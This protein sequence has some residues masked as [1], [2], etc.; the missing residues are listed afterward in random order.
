MANTKM[1]KVQGFAQVLA[2]VNGEIEEVSEDAI[3]I[4]ENEIARL[5]KTAEKASAKRTAK[6]KENEEMAV[7]VAEFLEDKEPMATAEIAR[8][9]EVSPQK[10]VAILKVGVKN[11]LFQRIE[12]K[13]PTYAS[14]DYEVEVDE[15]EDE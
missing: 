14:L 11:D 7:S 4:V 3:T 2:F 8:E 6:A 10:M 12:G 1:T 13:K 5:N 15:G 9:F